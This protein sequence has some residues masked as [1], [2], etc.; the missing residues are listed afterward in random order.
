VLAGDG[1]GRDGGAERSVSLLEDDFQALTKLKGD[2]EQEHDVLK[3]AVSWYYT[4][5]V[6]S[7]SSEN[8]RLSLQECAKATLV[9]RQM[10]GAGHSE[11]TSLATCRAL[12]VQTDDD[13]REAFKAFDKAGSGFIDKGELRQALPLMGEDIPEDK[14]NELFAA[15]DTDQSG[16]IDFDEFST[17]VK[18]MNSKAGSSMLSAFQGFSTGAIG[19]N[20]ANQFS[21]FGSGM[22]H[23]QSA[24]NAGLTDLGTS[25]MRK[26]GVIVDNFKEAGYSEEM[27]ATVCRALLGQ[28]SESDMKEAYKF[29]DAD[30][31][32]WISSEEMKKALP[33]MGEDVPQDKLDQLYV[34]IDKNNDGKV[35]FDEFS[36]CV[37]MMNPRDGSAGGG[38]SWLQENLGG[39]SGGLSGF[40]SGFGGFFGGGS[41]GAVTSGGEAG[42][43]ETG[44]APAAGGAAAGEA[45]E[46]KAES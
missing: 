46:K 2:G 27:A 17:L 18:G 30:N 11:D 1:M 28:Q 13:M 7:A 44:A 3:R 24:Y 35:A 36:E 15:V 23:I 33:L 20:I 39:L 14:I 4:Y 40:S 10:K 12:F 26:A 19:T 31:N 5:S 45:D 22:S 37:K 8:L 29:F 9:S 21:V 41:G 42:N 38:N 32:G 16:T 6:L 25:D 34:V 43:G